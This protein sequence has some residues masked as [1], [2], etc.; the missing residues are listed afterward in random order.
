AAAAAA[1]GKFD[2]KIDKSLL[3]DDRLWPQGYLRTE[4]LFP[5]VRD[6]LESGADSGVEE[7]MS[8]PRPA[9]IRFPST[10][11]TRLRRA[12]KEPKE[13]D[14]IDDFLR[15]STKS[16]PASD[17]FSDDAFW[18]EIEHRAME[19]IASSKPTATSK[20]QMAAFQS[21]AE[22][23]KELAALADSIDGPSVT[24]TKVHL[25]SASHS[26]HQFTGTAAPSVLS[27][28][29][30]TP[31]AIAAA[32]LGTRPSSPNVPTV[33]LPATVSHFD[34][35]VHPDFPDFPPRARGLHNVP[36]GHNTGRQIDWDFK[37]GFR[38]VN[39]NYSPK[40]L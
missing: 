18:K 35:G 33:A 10:R 22:A 9:I 29:S 7:K 27:Q 36:A 37:R 28:E 13:I 6:E 11:P 34:A 21:D 2:Q 26:E 12:A 39:K 24:G 19:D 14:E 30:V 38:V 25:N 40:R 8:A 20:I 31:T 5:P 17:D 3:Q 15:S 4:F 16:K 1:A 32:G 23:G